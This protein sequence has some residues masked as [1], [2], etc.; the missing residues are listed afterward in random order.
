[1]GA[2]VAMRFAD[3]GMGMDAQQ[4][5]RYFQPFSSSFHEG[6]G[7]GAAIVYRLV[8]EH[9]GRVRLESNAGRGTCVRIELPRCAC[10]GT[11]S[12]L[13]TPHAVMRSIATRRVS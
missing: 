12:R 6:T 11:I 13:C 2:R 8:E 3:E 9:G 1:M 10:S 7:L 4:Q 5:E